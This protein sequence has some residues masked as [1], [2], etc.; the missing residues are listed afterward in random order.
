VDNKSEALEDLLCAFGVFL[1]LWYGVL[2]KVILLQ[3][4]GISLLAL[5]TWRPKQSILLG[6]D[7]W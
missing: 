6:I 2:T 5:F 7:L 3:F 4:F 1:V